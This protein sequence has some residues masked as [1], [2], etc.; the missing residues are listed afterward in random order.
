MDKNPLSLK[1]KSYIYSCVQNKKGEVKN[2]LG[3]KFLIKYLDMDEAIMKT[4][5]RGFTIA[6]GFTV[7][8]DE[9]KKY[10]NAI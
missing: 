5:Y 8:L 4:N 10:F 2:G 3:R 1:E 6:V 7:F 9:I